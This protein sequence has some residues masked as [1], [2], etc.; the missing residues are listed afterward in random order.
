MHEIASTNREKA[1]TT[2][3]ISL[4]FA[5]CLLSPPEAVCRRIPH[6]RRLHWIVLREIYLKLKM[7]P[8]I[9][10][11]WDAIKRYDPSEGVTEHR[12]QA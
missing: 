1:E 3:Q 10:C 9:E 11:V 4:R 2:L 5:R 6:L 12:S 7:L 8:G